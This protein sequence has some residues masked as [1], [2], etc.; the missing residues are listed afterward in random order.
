MSEEDLET[1]L[2]RSAVALE[3]MTALALRQARTGRELALTQHVTLAYQTGDKVD[4]TDRHK[5]RLPTHV[6]DAIVESTAR[7]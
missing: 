1:E 7:L 4:S 2:H 5:L 3:Y 6:L